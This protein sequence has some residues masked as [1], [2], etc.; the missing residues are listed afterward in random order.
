MGGRLVRRA[1]RDVRVEMLVLAGMERGITVICV[2]R[3]VV[4]RIVENT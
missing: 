1:R 3:C 4:Q 2:S